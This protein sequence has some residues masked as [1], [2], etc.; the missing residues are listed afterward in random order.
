MNC[1]DYTVFV[2]GI[3]IYFCPIITFVKVFPVFYSDILNCK[4]SVDI[5]A[6]ACRATALFTA[7]T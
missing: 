5:N 7:D 2:T 4:I 6:W 1:V 3:K